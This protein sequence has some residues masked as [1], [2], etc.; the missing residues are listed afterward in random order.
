MEETEQAFRMCFAL[1]RGGQGGKEEGK[2]GLNQIQ[3]LFFRKVTIFARARGTGPMLTAPTHVVSSDRADSAPVH[4]GTVFYWRHLISHPLSFQSTEIYR[5]WSIPC[6]NW[7]RNYSC[8]AQ[9]CR[10]RLTEH[11]EKPAV[12]RISNWHFSKM[13]AHHLSSEDDGGNKGFE[14]LARS[15][16][17]K[18]GINFISNFAKV[19]KPAKLIHKFLRKKVNFMSA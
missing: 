3:I 18:I 14:L 1:G 2:F 10:S 6:I 12:S 19:E 5:S 7:N 4:S 16:N 17:C 13:S 15:E 8:K 11:R 9:L